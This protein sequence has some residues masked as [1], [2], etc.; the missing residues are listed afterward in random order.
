MSKVKRIV[1]LVLVLV[2]M[3]AFAS[4]VVSARATCPNCGSGDTITTRPYTRTYSSR[5]DYRSYYNGVHN[6][7]ITEQYTGIVCRSCGYNFNSTP[8]IISNVCPYR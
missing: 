6:H 3:V 2:L 4:M 1:A 7:T 8:V 5:V